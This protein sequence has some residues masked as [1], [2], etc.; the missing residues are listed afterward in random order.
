M[1]IGDNNV[2]EVGSGKSVILNYIGQTPSSI[3]LTKLNLSPKTIVME[4]MKIGN[5]NTLEV[6]GNDMKRAVTWFPL[7]HGVST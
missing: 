7:L 2:F 3:I 6:K 1:I 5:R 4:G